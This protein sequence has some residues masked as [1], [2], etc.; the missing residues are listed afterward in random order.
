MSAQDHP[1]VRVREGS[2]SEG[3]AI[4]QQL[5]EFSGGQLSQSDFEHRLNNSSAIVLVAEAD[6]QAVGFKAGYDRYA[7]GSFYSWLGGVVSDARRDGVA[8]AL[9]LEQER[10]V[11]VAG[12]DRIYVKTRNRFVGMLMLLLNNGYGVVGVKLPDDL[13]IADG[14]LTLLKVLRG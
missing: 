3:W 13:P 5:P 11:V 14:R 9:L 12:Y 8:Q 7:D 2:L 10:L 4:Y 6:G 1:P